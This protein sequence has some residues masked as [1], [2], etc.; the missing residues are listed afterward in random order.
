MKLKIYIFLI[1]KMI[2]ICILLFAKFLKVDF[3]LYGVFALGIIH[4][5]DIVYLYYMGLENLAHRIL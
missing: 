2:L 3:I 1:F 5:L 4:F